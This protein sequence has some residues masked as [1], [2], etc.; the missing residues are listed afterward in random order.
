MKVPTGFYN[1]TIAKKNRVQQKTQ[2][3]PSNY[4]MIRLLFGKRLQAVILNQIR[5][6]S[7]NSFFHQYIAKRFESY[8]FKLHFLGA[9]RE[10]KPKKLGDL[11][12]ISQFKTD[13][14][15]IVD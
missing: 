13:F 5:K 7:F 6:N 11:R 8:D 15:Y 10:K 4:N 9:K 12:L 14:Y 2:C 3:H 1:K